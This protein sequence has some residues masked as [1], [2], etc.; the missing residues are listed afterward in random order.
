MNKH[1]RAETLRTWVALN[2]VVRVADEPTC[3]ALLADETAGKCRKVF[4]NRLW[5]RI[6]RLRVNE[7]RRAIER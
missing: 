3:R 5:S 2:A 6:N 7:V 4:V 1:D